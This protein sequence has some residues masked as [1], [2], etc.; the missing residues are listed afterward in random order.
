MTEPQKAAHVELAEALETVTK[1]LARVTKER[2]QAMELL[3]E[4]LA[5]SR[6]LLAERDEAR[7]ILAQIGM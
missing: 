4:T 3:A 7:S 2:D 5:L 1:T 6:R